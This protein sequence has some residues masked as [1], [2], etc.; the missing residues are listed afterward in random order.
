[1]QNSTHNASQQFFKNEQIGTP[2]IMI[3]H[4]IK[5]TIPEVIRKPVNQLPDKNKIMYYEQ[6]VFNQ[7]FTK[8][9]QR[10]DWI[11]MLPESMLRTTIDISYK[12]SKPHY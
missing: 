5:G 4:I 11:C 1:M 2:K 7:L 12:I 8:T 6:M 9:L 3:F 10:T